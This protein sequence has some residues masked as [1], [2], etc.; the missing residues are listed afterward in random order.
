MHRIEA[1]SAGT[2][3]ITRPADAATLDGMA[4]VRVNRSCRIISLVRTDSA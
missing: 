4:I 2:R 1:D 3:I